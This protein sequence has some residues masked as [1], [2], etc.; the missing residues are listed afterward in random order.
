M[1]NISYEELFDA[2]KKRVDERPDFVYPAGDC[3]YQKDGEPSCLIGCALFDLG[4]PISNL[5]RLD[6][7]NNNTGKAAE[8]INNFDIP[9]FRFEQRALALAGRVQSNQDSRYS[10]REAL[11]DA[12][13]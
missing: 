9:D 11:R 4:V 8:F 10:W 5:S 1:K 2:I 13:Y 12:I 7:H 6:Q 3:K